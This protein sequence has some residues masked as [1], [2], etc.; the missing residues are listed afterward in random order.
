MIFDRW[1]LNSRCFPELSEKIFISMG[2]IGKV[3]SFRICG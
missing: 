3:D 1:L 2:V